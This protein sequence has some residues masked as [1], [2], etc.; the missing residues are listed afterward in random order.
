MQLDFDQQRVLGVLIEKAFTTPDQYPLT[1][2]YLINACNQKSCRRPQ[3]DLGELAVLEAL[4]ELRRLGLAT[5]VQTAGG[6]TDRY[7]QRFSEVIPVDRKELGVLAELLLRGPQ[8]DGELRQNA[9]RISGPIDDIGA[10][11]E[12]LLDREEPLVRRLGEDGRRRGVKYAHT[13]Y[14][15]GEEPAAEDEGESFTTPPTS[16]ATPAA[17]PGRLDELEATV[18]EL[19]ERVE[20]LEKALGP[21]RPPLPGPGPAESDA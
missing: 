5:V 16:R 14:P 21:E 1:L 17:S 4:D 20:R 18:L 19:V 12:G 8:T 6:R 11:L 13:L 2:N 10:I 9:R 3:T 15:E 7:R